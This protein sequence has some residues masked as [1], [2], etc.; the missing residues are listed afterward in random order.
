MFTQETD[1]TYYFLSFNLVSL[2]AAYIKYS[3]LLSLDL[4]W[5]AYH[6]Y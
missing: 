2:R 3:L 5:Q 6:G 1:N 4:F